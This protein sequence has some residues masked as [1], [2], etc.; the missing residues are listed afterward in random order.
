M[1]DS[2][3]RRVFSV[4]RAVRASV[5]SPDDGDPEKGVYRNVPNGA[6]SIANCL[7]LWDFEIH[8]SAPNDLFFDKR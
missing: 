5:H 1:K 2:S 3:S 6:V 8:K 7:I 4:G